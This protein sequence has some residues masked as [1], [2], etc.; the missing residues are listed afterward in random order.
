[1]ICELFFYYNKSNEWE[2]ILRYLDKIPDT[3]RIITS[4]LAFN[5]FLK[6]N[7]KI[8]YTLEEFIPMRGSEA[9]DVYKIAKNLLEEYRSILHN[10]TI[11]DIEIFNGF[12][13][14]F[15]RQLEL[16]IKAKKIL[17]KKK[18]TIFIFEGYREIYFS[19]MRLA[20][21]TGYENDLKI[22]YV[23]GDKIEYLIS[24]N[25]LVGTNYKNR[26]AHVKLTNFLKNTFREGN[27]I[28]SFKF[29]F[30]F[31]KQVFFLETNLLIHKFDLTGRKSRINTNLHKIDKKI[32]KNNLVKHVFFITGTREDLF[33]KPM[34]Q[35]IMKFSKEKIPFQI[36][37][38]D[39]A[40]SFVLGKAKIPFINLFED[41]NALL[42]EINDTEEGKKIQQEVSHV[43]SKNHSVLGM[44]DLSGYLSNQINRSLAV[45]LACEQI[46]NKLKLTSIFAVADGE[47][48]ENIAIELAR[49]Y[50]IPSMTLLPGIF[51]PF[52]HFLDWFHTDIICVNGINDFNSMI[53]LGYDKK[54]IV[55]TGSPKYDFI[56]T[57]DP[58]ESKIYL[59]NKHKI[60]SKKKLVLIARGSWEQDDEVWMS[61]LI[62]FCNQQNLEIIIKIHP[63]YQSK[64]QAL[65]E[66]KIKA[67]N[68]SC[69]NL[70]YLITYDE[71][72]NTLISAADVVL[73]HESSTVGAHASLAN[74]PLIAVDFLKQETDY[75]IRYHEIGAAMY[76]DEYSKL[77]ELILEILTEGKH[78]EKLTDGRKKITEMYNYKND[79]KA[80]D[81]IFNILINST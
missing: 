6:K 33:F 77:E 39:L 37:T 44:K 72:L 74:K 9:F 27:K 50:K 15:L 59:E 30:R 28:N 10:V 57:I 53:N 1:M 43:I 54:R 71:D 25:N 55:I 5:Q 4:S 67:I 14:S 18:N 81:R 31:I 21:E 38:T 73:F 41:V 75:P 62:K 3:Y 60:D 42:K 61:K 12:S 26:F 24:E 17:D 32:Q 2:T 78:F 47:T 23:K 63:L 69:K 70:Q 11:N 35:I 7:G 20:K 56:K 49:K 51:D 76:V 16:L 79:G 48:F 13:Y 58:A 29:I 22:N 34:Q 52:P 45:I 40:T 68:E 8:S 64:F 65:S 46:F 19:I 66:K 36:F 80:A